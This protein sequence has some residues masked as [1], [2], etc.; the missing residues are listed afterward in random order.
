LIGFFFFFFFFGYLENDVMA[1]Q[2]NF[3][4]SF[5]FFFSISISSL[6]CLKH[7][8]PPKLKLFIIFFLKKKD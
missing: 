2:K 4:F 3:S 6:Y 8:A 5:F 1:I 7:F